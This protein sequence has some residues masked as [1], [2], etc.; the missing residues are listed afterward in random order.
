MPSSLVTCRNIQNIYSQT[1][2]I[3]Y[4]YNLCH[5]VI[6]F[7][8]FNPWPLKF[9][10]YTVYSNI[11]NMLYFSNIYLIWWRDSTAKCNTFTLIWVLQHSICLPVNIE[12]ARLFHCISNS[13]QIYSIIQNA[14]KYNIYLDILIYINYYP[15][16]L[17]H[18]QKNLCLLFTEIYS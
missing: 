2:L 9:F 15:N 11:V 14:S 1:C 16:I 12:I 4:L 7:F 10:L 8:I 17:K 6:W 13:S 3:Q 5:C 18:I